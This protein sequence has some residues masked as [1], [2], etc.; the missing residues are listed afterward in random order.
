M[1]QNPENRW[2]VRRGDPLQRFLVSAFV[3]SNWYVYYLSMQQASV[4]KEN[5]QS[6]L[7]S[8]YHGQDTVAGE[9]WMNALWFCRRTL[10]CIRAIHSP[11]FRP[12]LRIL[13]GCIK[14]VRIEPLPGKRVEHAGVK[15]ELLGQIGMSIPQCHQVT[16][17]SCVCFHDLAMSHAGTY[18][19]IQ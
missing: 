15:I 4:K 6:E 14:Q 13:F 3:F 19:N 5:G 16:R 18:C 1:T 12:V 2:A 17:R 9:V 10:L 11:F 7:I 8:L